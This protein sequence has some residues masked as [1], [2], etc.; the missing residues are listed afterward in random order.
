MVLDQERGIVFV[1]SKTCRTEQYIGI[2]HDTLK[3]SLFMS[4]IS[5]F[6]SGIFPD[7]IKS[8]YHF[9][10]ARIMLKEKGFTRSHNLWSFDV[11]YEQYGWPLTIWLSKISRSCSFLI[12][13]YRDAFSIS[14]IAQGLHWDC[15][16]GLWIAPGWDSNC[17]TTIYLNQ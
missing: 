11:Q 4:A 8:C 2:K 17:G 15:A 16:T 14:W 12:S 7:L 13:Y 10:V 9:V 1:F 6:T 3:N 5:M